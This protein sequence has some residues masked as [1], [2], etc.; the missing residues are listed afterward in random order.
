MFDGKDDGH[1][2]KSAAVAS[3]MCSCAFPRTDGSTSSLDRGEFHHIQR[4]THP[5]C[6]PVT[7][8]PITIHLKDPLLPIYTCSLVEDIFCPNNSRCDK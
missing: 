5:I 1:T 7:S 6:D 4:P 2:E 3:N 8:D